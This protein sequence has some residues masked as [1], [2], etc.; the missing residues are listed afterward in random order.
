MQVWSPS[1][2]RLSAKPPLKTETSYRPCW[3]APGRT[4]RST[5][6]GMCSRKSMGAIAS[7]S[8]SKRRGGRERR[9][10]REGVQPDT[11]SGPNGARLELDG[12]RPAR[13][14]ERLTRIQPDHYRVVSCYLKL[15]PRDRS[16]GKY[17]IKLKKRIKPAVHG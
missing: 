10:G 12:R 6:S 2:S 4:A 7:R 15:E 13:L 9:K 14:L 3:I 5:R 17:F 1:G 8:F 11:Y 16:R